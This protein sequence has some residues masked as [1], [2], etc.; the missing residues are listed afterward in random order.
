MKTETDLRKKI[1]GLI[2]HIEMSNQLKEFGNIKKT[3]IDIREYSLDI[4]ITIESEVL[5]TVYLSDM[6]KFINF[7][8]E[9]FETRVNLKSQFEKDALIVSQ[10]DLETK[11]IFYFKR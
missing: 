5:L 2:G 11:F 10:T 6:V 7:V 9:L 8:Y 3:E 4:Q 1:T